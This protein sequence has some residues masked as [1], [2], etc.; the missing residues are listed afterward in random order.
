MMLET[1]LTDSMANIVESISLWSPSRLELRQADV[2]SCV[3]S[4]GLVAG[5]AEITLLLHLYMSCKENLDDLLAWTPSDDVS[6]LENL[7]IGVGRAA[8]HALCGST[9]GLITKISNLEKVLKDDVELV[10]AVQSVVADLRR[11]QSA[12]ESIAELLE[13]M[14]L[15]AS[16]G[17]P[18]TPDQAAA[19][20]KARGEASFLSSAVAMLS[21]IESVETSMSLNFGVLLGADFEADRLAADAYMF[22]S[23]LGSSNEDATGVRVSDLLAFKDTVLVLPIIQYVQG[24]R[25]E[26][27]A[28]LYA[29]FASTIA[30]DAIN[31]VD[32]VEKPISL[33]ALC[34][35]FVKLPQMTVSAAALT[36]KMA[37]GDASLDSAAALALLEELVT[38]T[39][40]NTIMIGGD[41][42]QPPF[43]LQKDL[44]LAIARVYM[45]VHHVTT[46]IA[47]LGAA[48]GGKSG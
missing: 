25:A 5:A 22:K 35:R 39:S 43:A 30:L 26:R 3:Q 47:R 17:L 24:I 1:M 11:A 45:R 32:A 6:V 44:A 9:S 19:Q 33:T 12:R 34:E 10:K 14:R 40:T 27:A 37:H 16:H 28:A 46:C 2:R 23:V 41:I 48:C 29:T 15:V 20:W 7:T 13:A 36:S 8:T 4:L 21:C 31:F 42:M 18:T 38:I